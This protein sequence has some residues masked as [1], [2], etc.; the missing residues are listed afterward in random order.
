[1]AERVLA[2]QGWEAWPRCSQ[3]VGLR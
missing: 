2:D 1:V 3:M